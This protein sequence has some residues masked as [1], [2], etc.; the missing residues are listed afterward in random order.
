MKRNA[1]RRRALQALLE[2]LIARNEATP[3]EQARRA[4]ILPLLSTRISIITGWNN[5]LRCL[6]VADAIY[7]RRR[8]A[9]LVPGAAQPEEVSALIER[10]NVSV[11]RYMLRTAPDRVSPQER[12]MLAAWDMQRASRAAADTVRA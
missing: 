11:I 4:K 12:D 6:R 9:M 1:K 5:A 10:A 2:E 3:E 8:G 7:H